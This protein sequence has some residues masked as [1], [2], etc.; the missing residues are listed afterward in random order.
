MRHCCDFEALDIWY[1]KDNEKFNQRIIYLG[2]CPICE[3]L[4]VFLSQKN[5][6]TGVFVSVKK[7]GDSA[8]DFLKK[9]SKEVVFSKSSVNKQKFK[10]KTHGW[11]YGVNKYKSDGSGST[12]LEQYAVDFHGNVELIKKKKLL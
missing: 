2:T 4:V 9:H 7:A 10:T 6:E 1:L 5:I 8:K 3:K 11:K 12:I